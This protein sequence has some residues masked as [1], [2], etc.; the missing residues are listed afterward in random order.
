MR[1]KE[2]RRVLV[3]Q[4][5]DQGYPLRKIAVMLFSEGFYNKESEKP[6]SYQTMHND[7]KKKEKNK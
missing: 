4:L 3:K 6:F 5:H 1:N 2:K 7:L